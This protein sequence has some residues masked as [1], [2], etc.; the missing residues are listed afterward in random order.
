MK[1]T[2]KAQREYLRGQLET[3]PKWAKV[4]LLRIYD[5]QTEEEQR[6]RDTAEANGIGFSGVDGMILS[7]FAIQLHTKKYLSPRQMIILMSKMKR[8]WRQILEIT[9]IEKL[10]SQI[11]K[12]NSSKITAA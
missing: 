7:S 12:L 11:E 2:K 10:N 8:Y 6:C 3:N 1:I 9:D 4:A 5:N